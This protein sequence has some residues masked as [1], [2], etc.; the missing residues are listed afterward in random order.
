MPS[1]LSRSVPALSPSLWQRTLRMAVVPKIALLWIPVTRPWATPGWP[2]RSARSARPQTGIPPTSRE[3]VPRPGRSK[4]ANPGGCLSHDRRHDPGHAADVDVHVCTASPG[5][6]SAA[7]TENESSPCGVI[8]NF[9]S[10]GFGVATTIDPVIFAVPPADS[11]T[12]VGTS[13]FAR[14]S[15]SFIFWVAFFCFPSSSV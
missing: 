8:S 10:R 6:K 9:T 7:P 11:C 13:P 3:S 4:R 5:E 15:G 12:S 14:S 2:T 1:Y